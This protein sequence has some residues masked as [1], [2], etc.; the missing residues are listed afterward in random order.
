MLIGGERL[1]VLS[2]PL[3]PISLPDSLSDAERA[4]ARALIAGASNG[5]IAAA[6]RTSVRTV[7]NQVSS[8]LRKLGARSRTEAI[9]ALCENPSVSD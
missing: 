9:A 8:L 4:V 2:F 3:V 7:A 6:R 5:Q 1:A